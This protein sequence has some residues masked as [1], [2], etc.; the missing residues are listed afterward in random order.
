MNPR[1][2]NYILSVAILI[3]LVL[4]QNGCHKS[5]QYKDM[6]DSMNDSLKV[7]RN[8]LGQERA[9]ISALK[10]E[11]ASIL[12]NAKTKD[13]TIQ[14]LQNVV[15]EYEGRLETAVVISNATET[16][17]VIKEVEV[18]SIDTVY[19]DSLIFVYPQ[20]KAKW[21]NKWE[22]GLILATRDSIFRDITVFN[23]YEITIGK[24]KN[25][26]FKPREY[27]INVLN[28]NPRTTTKE[29][30]SFALKA[31]PKRFVLSVQTGVGVHIPSMR[32]SLY[33][34]IGL[35]FVLLQIK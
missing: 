5:S 2:L 12:L 23:D 29:V 34:G 32:P 19:Q 30:R 33:L 16:V 28:L 4:W 18:E 9:T 21:S 10:G 14:W 22:K 24:E 31:K 3:L 26:W 6:R 17:E 11:R 13:S 15:K 25:K 1:I 8:E 20:Y 7:V 35:G 27:N